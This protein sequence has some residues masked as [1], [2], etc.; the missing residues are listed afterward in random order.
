VL[1]AHRRGVLLTVEA[2]TLEW[3]ARE[4]ARLPFAFTVLAPAELNDE[5]RRL[6]QRLLEGH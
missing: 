1:K 4:L 2:E 6:A 3:V 5:V